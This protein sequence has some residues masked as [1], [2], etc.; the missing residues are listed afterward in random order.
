MLEGLA[1]GMYFFRLE[2]IGLH[3]LVA[4][5][6]NQPSVLALQTLGRLRREI[7]FISTKITSCHAS[8]LI[9]ILMILVIIWLAVENWVTI[10]PLVIFRWNMARHTIIIFNTKIIIILMIYGCRNF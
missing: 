10:L 2:S 7:I 5:S 6:K 9:G 3:P 1:F 8:I 4:R